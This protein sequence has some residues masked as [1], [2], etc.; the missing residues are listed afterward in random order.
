[1]SK[2]HNLGVL[3]YVALGAY[4]RARR[5]AGLMEFHEISD[6]IWAFWIMSYYAH[7]SGDAGRPGS[8]SS[9]VC[10]CTQYFA[11]REGGLSIK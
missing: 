9:I 6:I 4:L 11:H 3:D 8:W 10:R 1:M 2:R 5:A 7:T